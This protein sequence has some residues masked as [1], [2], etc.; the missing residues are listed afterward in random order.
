MRADGFG[1]ALSAGKAGEIEVRVSHR[2]ITVA[3]RSGGRRE[4][5]LT[6]P[7]CDTTLVP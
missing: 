7:G 6:A 4:L 5:S 3:E 1:V 2:R